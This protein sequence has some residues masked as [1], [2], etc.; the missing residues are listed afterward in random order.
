VSAAGRRRFLLP[1]LVVGVVA[2]TFL[3]LAGARAAGS[4]VPT[5]PCLEAIGHAQSG[6]ENGYR[7]VLGVVSVPPAHL[8][9]V[10]RARTGPWRYWRK[11]GLAIRTGSSPVEV[12]VPRAW[13]RRV[14]ITWGDTGPVGALR[15]EGCPPPATAWSA[16]AG[17]FY[18]RAPSC[19]PVVLQVGSR[20]A[21]VWLGVGRRCSRSG[22]GG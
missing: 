9:Q 21:T 5:V 22:T 2:G 12:S 14:A 10:V 11:A 16:Y 1:P 18:L 20:K 8:G 17:G 4:T 19:V 13:R 7:I 3:S 15:I 6:R